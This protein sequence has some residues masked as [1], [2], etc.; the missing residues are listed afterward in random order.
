V[1]E[2]ERERKKERG[3]ERKYSIVYIHIHISISMNENK[4][5][6]HGTFLLTTCLHL[7]YIYVGG[8]YIISVWGERV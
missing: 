2:R 5:E 1:P 3:W 4:Y 8:I 7:F 6:I